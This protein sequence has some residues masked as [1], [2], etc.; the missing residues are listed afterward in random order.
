MVGLGQ[1]RAGRFI[2]Y[3]C[4]AVEVFIF[5]GLSLTRQGTR[6]LPWLL[7]NY[8]SQYQ[9]RTQRAYGWSCM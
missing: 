9:H 1:E 8:S 5:L 3:V 6:A 7:L 4:P 2:Y